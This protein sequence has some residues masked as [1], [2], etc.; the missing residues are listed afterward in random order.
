MHRREVTK[1]ILATVTSFA[2]M[3][4]LF[5][6]NAIGKNIKPITDHWAIKLHEY[7]SDLKTASISAVQWQQKIEELYAKVEL[8]EI[9]DFIDFNNLIKGFEHPDLGVST[10]PIKFPKLEGLPERTAFVKKIFGM[11][12]DRAIIPHGHSNMASAHL[13]LNGEM[14]LRH[15]EKIEHDGQNLIIKPS[16]D[17]IAKAGESSSISDEKDNVHWFIAHTETAFTFDVIML[18]LNGKHY[19]IHNLDIYESEDL[20]N[21]TLKVPILDVQTALKKYGKQHH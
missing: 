9:L 15:Y 13:I 7:C 20:K 6:F 18:D 3:D 5:A 14:H 21:G 10:K 19:H 11:K 1:G 8:G 4:S 16:I 2:L 17:Q 12:K